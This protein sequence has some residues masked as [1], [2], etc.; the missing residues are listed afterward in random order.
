M[1]KSARARMIAV[2]A[3]GVLLGYAA[4]SSRLGVFRNA[5]AG[6]SQKRVAEAAAGPALRA[7]IASPVTDVQKPAVART[8]GAVK[9][10]TGTC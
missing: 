2:L 7:P 4:A 3:I 9:A 10:A 1:M 6:P 8:I 5:D